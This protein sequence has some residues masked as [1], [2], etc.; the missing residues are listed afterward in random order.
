MNFDGEFGLSAC[1]FYMNLLSLG[2]FLFSLRN[3]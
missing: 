2:D 3:T 1:D